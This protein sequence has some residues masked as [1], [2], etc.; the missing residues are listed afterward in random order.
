METAKPTRL[1]FVALLYL[2][3]P[4]FL[5][6]IG[7]CKWI[8]A[9]PAIGFLI[10]ILAFVFKRIEYKNDTRN[11]QTVQLAITAFFSLVWVA[12]T[13]VWNL[14]FGRTQDWDVMRNDLLSTL[15]THSWP[16]THVFSDSSALWSMRHYLSFYLPG[17]LAGKVTG[18]NL[19]VTLFTT[20]VWMFLGHLDYAN[21]YRFHYSSSLVD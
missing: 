14:G 20:G 2:T 13:G 16:V 5:F 11:S 18:N 21:T 12:T 7:W 6:F 19:G 4:L 3:F 17:P 10:Y 15:T 8:V 1:Y 9:I